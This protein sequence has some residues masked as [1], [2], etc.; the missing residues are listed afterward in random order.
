M[1][2][3]TIA[4]PLG[5]HRIPRHELTD[6]QAR[7]VIGHVLNRLG[8]AHGIT[9]DT[10]AVPYTATRERRDL[11]ELAAWQLGLTL[12][13]GCEIAQCAAC[14]AIVDGARTTTTGGIVRCTD[15]PQPVQAPDDDLWA[16]F[17][18]H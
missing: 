17:Y 11:S 10:P 3:S 9:E 4:A 2:P 5:R 12:T 1:T 16:D 6:L 14:G 15:C 18:A 8:S 7:F 13:D